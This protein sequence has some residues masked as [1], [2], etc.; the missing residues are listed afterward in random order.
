MKKMVLAI[1]VIVFFAFLSSCATDKKSVV[2]VSK[3]YTSWMS[4]ADYQKEFNRQVQLKNYP[5]EVEGRC[6]ST[7]PQYRGLFKY[8]PSDLSFWSH[9]GLNGNRFNERDQ[10]L[11]NKGYQRVWHQEFECSGKTLHQGIWIKRN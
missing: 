3:Q 11:I 7:S 9:H 6:D 1:V 10:E 2:E 5:E 8:K 4:A